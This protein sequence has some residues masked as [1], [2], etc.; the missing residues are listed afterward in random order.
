MIHCVAYLRRI[1]ISN[2]S[3]FLLLH[4]FVFWLISSHSH[5]RY[6][7]LRIPIMTPQQMHPY[8]FTHNAHDEGISTI[9][10]YIYTIYVEYERKKGI[11]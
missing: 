10:I 8:T 9:Y 5:S 3:T 1:A 7:A 2:K 6:G 11:K 4:V